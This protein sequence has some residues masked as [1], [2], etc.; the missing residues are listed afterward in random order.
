MQAVLFKFVDNRITALGRNYDQL[1]NANQHGYWS[2]VPYTLIFL[3]VEPYWK[4]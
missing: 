1:R 3:K 2:L 4:I